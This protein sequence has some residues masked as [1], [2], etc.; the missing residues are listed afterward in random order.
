MSNLVSIII[1][2]FNREKVLQETLDSVLNQTHQNWECIIID[3]GSIDDTI[4]IIENNSKK[5]PRFSLYLRNKTTKPKGVSSCRNIGIEK[6]KGNFVIFLDSD[7]LLHKD[8]LKSRLNFVSKTTKSDVYVFQMQEF[9][10]KGLKKKCNYYPDDITNQKEYLKMIL[11]HQIPFSVT[12]PFWRKEAILLLNGFDEN[13]NRLEDP[14]F[15]CRA[16]LKELR[17]IFDV[18]SQPDCYYRVDEVS[19]K[20]FDDPVFKEVFLTSYFKFI[21]KYSSLNSNFISIREVKAELNLLLL[22]VF[23]EYLLIKPIDNS[24]YKIFYNIGKTENLLSFRERFLITILKKYIDNN[25]HKISGS[26]F[27]RLRK[28]TFLKLE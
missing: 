7:D 4:S 19:L 23:K 20:R 1:P 16:F 28:N 8:C 5:D 25:L 9:D 3:D 21:K 26:G 27:Y 14:D 11:R 10:S 6:A 17:F 2:V 15:H 13:L 12:C 22:R 24:Q 18:E